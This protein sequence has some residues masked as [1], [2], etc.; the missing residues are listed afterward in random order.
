[1]GTVL[2]IPPAKQDTLGTAMQRLQ[3]EQRAIVARIERESWFAGFW[4]GA[5]VFA[6][7]GVWAG[8]IAAHFAGATP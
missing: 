3:F 2:Y 7:L 8:W 4:W 1:M 6:V 5:L